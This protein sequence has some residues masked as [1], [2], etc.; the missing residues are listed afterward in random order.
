MGL[1]AFPTQ[2]RSQWISLC[3]RQARPLGFRASEQHNTTSNQRPGG[4]QTKLCPIFKFGVSTN[5][6]LLQQ[7]RINDRL[8]LSTNLSFKRIGDNANSK[9]VFTAS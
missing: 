4:Q 7:G 9:H 1:L 6:R 8:R 3:C 5:V 2:L